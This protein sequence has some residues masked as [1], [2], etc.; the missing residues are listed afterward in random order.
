MAKKQEPDKTEPKKKVTDKKESDKKES[1]K[2]V[3]GKKESPKKDSKKKPNVFVRT[4]K[5]ISRYFRDVISEI[6]KIV[7][8]TPKATFKNTGIVLVAMLVVGLII[9]GLDMGLHALFGL[10]M[11]LAGN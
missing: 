4:G 9:F 5:K 1:K 8:P 10:V 3:S 7:W 11:D 2:K 6:K